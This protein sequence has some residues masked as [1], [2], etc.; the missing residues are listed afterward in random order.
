MQIRHVDYL[1]KP[2]FHF[3]QHSYTIVTFCP[4]LAV[5]QNV[6]IYPHKTNDQRYIWKKSIVGA[7]QQN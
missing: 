7:N 2:P 1:D 5:S 3:L 4:L 6:Q